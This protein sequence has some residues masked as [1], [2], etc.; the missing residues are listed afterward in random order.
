[1]LKYVKS[2]YKKITM[3]VSFYHFFYILGPKIFIMYNILTMYNIVNLLIFILVICIR[4]LQIG[5]SLH[6]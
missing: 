3:V 2:D 5:P 6:S 1:M 4:I